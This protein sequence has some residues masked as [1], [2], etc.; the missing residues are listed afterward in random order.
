MVDGNSQMLKGSRF[1][2]FYWSQCENV[3]WTETESSHIFE[4]TIKAFQQLNS[5][6]KHYRK[7]E[8]SKKENKWIIYDEIYNLNN[9]LKKQI[10]HHDDFKPNFSSNGKKEINHESY[11]S[12]YYGSKERGK[13][14]VFTFDKSITTHIT[15]N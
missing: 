2:W 9:N 12:S 14:T 4:G 13:A 11:N 7:V 15:I 3:K 1:I 6:T 5:N 8:V 10:W